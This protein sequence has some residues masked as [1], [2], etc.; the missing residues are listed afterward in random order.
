MKMQVPAELRG[1]PKLPRKGNELL[2]LLC[3]LR[4]T[5]TCQL[6]V[7]SQIFWLWGNSQLLFVFFFRWH[8]WLLLFFF[9]PLGWFV[10][11][12]LLMAHKMVWRKHE[13]QK[14][15]CYAG[16]SFV[17]SE[18]TVLQSITCSSSVFWGYCCS[19]ISPQYENDGRISL[20]H[21]RGLTDYITI[22]AGHRLAWFPPWFFACPSEHRDPSVLLLLPKE[23][24][25]TLLGRG[26]RVPVLRQVQQSS[27]VPSAPLLW[28]QAEER[29]FQPSHRLVMGLVT[30]AFCTDQKQALFHESTDKLREGWG[31]SRVWR[32]SLAQGVPDWKDEL[33]HRSLPAAWA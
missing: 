13:Q 1:S 29:L 21:E 8:F 10:W 2:L 4:V 30:P 11:D 32:Q 28:Q 14:K 16:I 31:C 19:Q 25:E 9:F 33:R 18:Q 7:G 26:E 15:N 20:Q 22:K 24:P 5:E 17:R 12:S 23:I 3:P 6:P 27:W